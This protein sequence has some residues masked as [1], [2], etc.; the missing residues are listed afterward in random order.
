MT[1]ALIDTTTYLK[2]GRV[3]HPLLGKS[4][5]LPARQCK[6]T[7]DVARE[8]GEK[9]A[10]HNSFH[11]FPESMYADNRA[12]N[13]ISVLHLNLSLVR[14]WKISIGDL[15]K[16]SRREFHNV[17]LTPPSPA[18]CHLLACAKV[19]SETNEIKALV[20]SDDGGVRYAATYFDICEALSGW[21]LMKCLF[22]QDQLT[23]S[24]IKSIYDELSYLRELPFDW[25]ENSMSAFGFTF[26]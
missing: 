16:H 9:A 17:G 18:D 2:L 15:A 24:Q 14:S 22:D 3:L 26:P 1:F 4:I 7:V 6:I 12:E 21:E 23:I 19:I 10:L 5:K 25:R 11:W 13:T 8:Y 20:V